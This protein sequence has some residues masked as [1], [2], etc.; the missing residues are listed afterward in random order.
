MRQGP[1]GSGLGVFGFRDELGRAFGQL[2][3]RAVE[4]GTV[5]DRDYFSEAIHEC[6]ALGQLL[7]DRARPA[8]VTGIPAGRRDW[9]GGSGIALLELR[10]RPRDLG[11]VHMGLGAHHLAGQNA[12]LAQRDQHSPLGYSNTVRRPA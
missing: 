8:S 4:G 5:C 3:H 1:A 6:G 11:L 12:V 10:H 9:P 2:L 7:V